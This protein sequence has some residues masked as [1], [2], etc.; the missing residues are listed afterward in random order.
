[1]GR[2]G[3][4]LCSFREIQ[5]IWQRG[6]GWG[7]QCCGRLAMKAMLALKK[8]CPEQ[9]APSLCHPMTALGILSC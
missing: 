9:E 6:W 1:M 4:L 5:N 3:F 2:E 8:G 7:V